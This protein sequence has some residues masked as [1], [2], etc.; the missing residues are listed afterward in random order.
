MKAWHNVVVGVDGSEGS[1]RALAWAAEAARE[2]QAQLT[3]DH[4]LDPR[5]PRWTGYGSFRGYPDADFSDLQ[6]T[7]SLKR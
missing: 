5:R 3:V 1:R 2:H 7:R 4:G 6:N